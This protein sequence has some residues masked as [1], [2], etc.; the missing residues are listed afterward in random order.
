[1]LEYKQ[2]SGSCYIRRLKLS[3]IEES[4]HITMWKY[5]QSEKENTCMYFTFV[6]TIP[7]QVEP[8]SQLILNHPLS[9]FYESYVNMDAIALTIFIV[10]ITK[11][12]L[13]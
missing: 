9:D 11:K 7:N 4:L 6:K 8:A 13:Q 2:I 5:D 3:G 12:Q 10:F 1:M